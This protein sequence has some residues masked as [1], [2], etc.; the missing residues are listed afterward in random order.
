MTLHDVIKQIKKRFN[1]L[2]D[3][4][5]SVMLR[6][7]FLLQKALL[8]V[9]DFSSPEFFL[10]PVQ[11]FPCP[12]NCRWVSENV[13]MRV[14]WYFKTDYRGFCRTNNN[15]HQSF[16][17]SRCS[18]GDSSS[19]RISFAQWHYRSQWGSPEARSLLIE[20]L[21]QYPA[22]RL[23]IQQTLQFLTAWT[24]PTQGFKKKNQVQWQPLSHR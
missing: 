1:S 17:S 22:R 9:L 19:S 3:L 8:L 15:T 18:K 12:T 16:S 10:S 13:V 6:L 23:E 2:G 24:R 4:I 20:N 7:K 11:S 5:S 14:A 21:S